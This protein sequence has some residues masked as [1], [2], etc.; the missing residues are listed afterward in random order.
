MSENHTVSVFISTDNFGN[1]SIQEILNSLMEQNLIVNTSPKNPVNGYDA[2]WV[3]WYSKG[4][5]LALV[6]TDVFIII[7]TDS[8]ESSTWM[9]EEAHR[10][11]ELFTKGKI[12]KMA[13][14][15]IRT[16]AAPFAFGMKNYLRDKIENGNEIMRYLKTVG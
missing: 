16:F 1:V 5:Q 7:L 12:K 9:A 10:A 14:V 4:L 8:W 2:K 13:Y 15:D 3:D 11:E 6:S